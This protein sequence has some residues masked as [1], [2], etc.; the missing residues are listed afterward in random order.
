MKKENNIPIH[1]DEKTSITDVLEELM[2]AK[3]INVDRLSQATDIP[4]RF[5]E[6]LVA[7]KFN[8]LPAKPY[9]RGYLFKIAGVLDVNPGFLWRS[10]RNTTDVLSSGNLDRLPTNRFAIKRVKPSRV[11]GILF[12]ILILSLIGFRFNE[13]LGKPTLEL[14]GI[15]ESTPNSSIVVIG[16]VRVPSDTVTLNGE[17]I[18]PDES[19]RFEKEVQL[20]SGPNPYIL[21]FTA[22]RYLGREIKIVKQVFYQ[23]Q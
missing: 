8:D 19:G 18:Y 20:Q 17:V 6:S 23:P 3:G 11:V 12:I 7:G 13:I 14:E 15:P 5:I 1:M 21:E 22:K 2:E 10:Y 4:R 16:K 9:V